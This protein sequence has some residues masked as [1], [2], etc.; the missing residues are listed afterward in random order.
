MRLFGPA[1][2]SSSVVRLLAAISCLSL[3]AVVEPTPAAAGP[4]NLT[5]V[6]LDNDE[7]WNYDFF[8]QS[9]EAGNVDWAIDLVFY[10]NAN[11]NK[12]KDALNPW[13][14]NIGGPKFE[15]MRDGPNGTWKWDQD[16][17][18]KLTGCPPTG[19]FEHYRVYAD[20]GD[21]SMYNVYY[22]YYILGST[23]FDYND[24]CSGQQAGY[25]ETGE[26]WIAYRSGQAWGTDRVFYS[27]CTFYNA[28]AFRTE[29]TDGIPHI[30]ENNGNATYVSVP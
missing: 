26:T 15:Y 17:G 22:G 12:V 28:E 20:P 5:I 21:D 24:G 4:S 13:Y 10:N 7:F 18:R 9:A 1:T 2:Q 19:W 8:G 11:I 25:S 29:M 23:H 14:P 30:W 16:G 3:I 27:C 6:G